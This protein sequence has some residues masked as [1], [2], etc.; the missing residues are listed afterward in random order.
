MNN[1]NISHQYNLSF[2]RRDFLKKLSLIPLIPYLPACQVIQQPIWDDKFIKFKQI[3]PIDRTLGDHVFREFNGDDFI[4]P[5]QILWNKPAFIKSIGGLPKPKQKTELVIIGGGMS[6]L[7]SAY[8]LRNKKPV[9]LEQAKRFG[10]NA[11]GEAWNGL[12]YSIGAAYLVKPEE[13][14]EFYKVLTDIGIIK[15]WTI[16]KGGDESV[17]INGKKI[18]RFWQAASEPHF[19]AIYRKLYD[20]F[21]SY[22]NQGGNEFPDYP[23]N[24]IKL[25]KYINHLDQESF[26]AHLERM[27]G[28]SLPPHLATLL[29]HYCF[30][31][32]GGSATEISAA[33]GINFFAPELTDIAVFPGG[34]SYIAEALLKH[35]YKTIPQQHLLSG[36]MV[37]DV[38]KDQG[39]VLVSYLD[40]NSQV[41]SIWAEKAIMACPKFVVAKLID[42]LSE[43][44]KAAISCLEYRAYI[45]ANLL[46]ND[47]INEKEYDLYW[48]GQAKGDIADVKIYAKSRGITDIVNASFASSN[49]QETVLTFYQ[50]YPYLGGRTELY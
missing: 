41:Q 47:K 4:R 11:K 36:S 8:L 15:D 27:V 22:N 12:H 18:E 14:S 26:K 1:K 2:G 7:M 42:N 28:S 9:I 34:N 35:L 5:H 24:D 50:A 38:R 17:V 10:G 33:A 37:F 45:V 31:S 21:M 23:T 40:A 43:D 39:G 49:S 44:K 48:L 3:S 6:G 25:R 20:Y 13:D 32:F 29:E 19:I 30:S 16:K 46:I